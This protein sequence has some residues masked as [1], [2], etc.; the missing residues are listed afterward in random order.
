MDIQE[1][2]QHCKDI[3]SQGCNECAKEHMQLAAWLE[4]LVEMRKCLNEQNSKKTMKREEQIRK[5]GEAER[6]N[7]LNSIEE[8]RILEGVICPV[9]YGTG[10]MDGARWADSNPPEN[11]GW[12]SAGEAPTFPKD[13]DSVSVI[14]L[15]T[16]D[17]GQ[18]HSAQMDFKIWD[19]WQSLKGLKWWNYSPIQS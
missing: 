7:L 8:G 6:T 10:F 5:Q 4:E 12:H 17:D 14:V 15:Y 11:N 3:A 1:A 2:I 9:S 19:N 16:G 18:L 13:K